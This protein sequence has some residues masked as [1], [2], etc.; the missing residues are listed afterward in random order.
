[1]NSP[2]SL[3]QALDHLADEF[4]QQWRSGSRPNLAQFIE[5]SGVAPP[6]RQELLFELIS[7]DMEYRWR[8][9]ASNPAD[10]RGTPPLL[11]D[12]ATAWPELSDAQL[13]A[14][15]VA[16]EYRIRH[17]WGDA[18]DQAAYLNRFAGRDD[19]AEALVEVEE[20]L[21]A[22][23]LRGDTHNLL[24]SQQQRDTS[25][26]GWL[27]QLCELNRYRLVDKLGEGGMGQVYLMEDLQ[28]NRRVA[29]K[30]PRHH[31]DPSAAQRLL[32]EARA[33]AAIH[34][35]NVCPVFDMGEAA[36]QPF[37]IMAYIEGESLADR[38]VRSGPC[39]L[40]EIGPLFAK[41][42]DA[43]KEAHA[44]GVL[45]RDLK[46]SNVM[47]DR[48]GEPMLM[49]FG[50]ALQ[51]AANDAR[52]TQPG[53]RIGSPAYMAPEQLSESVGEVGPHTDIYGL[54]VIL[55]ETL[56][57]RVPF[58]GNLHRTIS[59][60]LHDDPPPVSSARPDIPAELEQLCM[61]MLAKAPG[62]RP[63][64]HEVEQAFA[65]NPSPQW[66][67]PP[68]PAATSKRWSPLWTIG[69]TALA[70]LLMGWLGL[71]GADSQSDPQP[72]QPSSDGKGSDT[73]S[74]VPN[75]TSLPLAAGQLWVGTHQH[76]HG[77]SQVV[78]SIDRAGRKQIEATLYFA[79]DRGLE[80]I[81]CTGRLVNDRFLWERSGVAYD[82][83]IRGGRMQGELTGGGHTGTFDLR[84]QNDTAI[85][86]L[87]GSIW[88]GTQ[89]SAP[90]REYNLLLEVEQHKGRQ[91][92]GSL[93]RSDSSGR[94]QQSFTG[95]VLG[96]YLLITTDRDARYW[97]HI[98]GR[99]MEGSTYDAGH[100]GTFRLTRTG[101]GDR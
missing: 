72:A 67:S 81:A 40:A 61:R 50:L 85:P 89:S 97:A 45:H 57:G 101:Q 35:P 60:V 53:D 21:S 42:T 91:I 39:S 27:D 2:A 66:Q 24:A 10:A 3:S 69:L 86:D 78:L 29:L 46:P 87:A 63:S 73:L 74:A 98:T 93:T 48:R 7:I 76:G 47:I 96:H 12:Y 92:S 56:T 77:T 16:E 80:G 14:S 22:D 51:P 62:V 54:G 9:A 83:R 59:Q 32:L 71:T 30:K 58:Q 84:L 11:R 19:V 75:A 18:P 20:E 95:L 4:D 31:L 70:L 13:P 1:M 15:I 5:R 65:A 90:N 99:T 38:L 23:R 34:H 36:G 55:Y 25:S 33:A 26:L 49:D 17:R 68:S 6:L 94:Y 79:L 52:L 88:E 100:G 28:L 41:L 44:C 64:L 43:L 37:I 8:A 82:G